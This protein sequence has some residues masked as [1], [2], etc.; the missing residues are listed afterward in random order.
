MRSTAYTS[1]IGACAALAALVGCA[2]QPLRGVVPEREPE[3]APVRHDDLLSPD[4]LA[5][6]DRWV[7]IRRC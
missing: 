1:I 2:Y 5:V 4:E 6:C 3:D 7:P